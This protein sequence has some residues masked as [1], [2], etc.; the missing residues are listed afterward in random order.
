MMGRV[1]EDSIVA[2]MG[3]VQCPVSDID[4][5][6]TQVI[7]SQLMSERSGSGLVQSTA[8]TTN[9]LKRVNNNHIS[10]ISIKVGCLHLICVWMQMIC[11]YFQIYTTDQKPLLW[12]IKKY[13]AIMMSPQNA[14]KHIYKIKPQAKKSENLILGKKW[15]W[16][17][18]IIIIWAFSPQIILIDT[19]ILW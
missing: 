7:S 4:Q 12:L 9:S 13:S 17:K 11:I 16:I 19:M 5:G 2:G 18:G 6:K 8:N 15:S 14:W 3:V 1:W 10:F